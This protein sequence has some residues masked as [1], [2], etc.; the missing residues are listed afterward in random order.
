MCFEIIYIQELLQVSLDPRSI[1]EYPWMTLTMFVDGGGYDFLVVWSFQK[2]SKY[3][4]P[5]SCTSLIPL[6]CQVEY[7]L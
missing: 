1:Q 6:A 3:I 7:N 4:I 2:N 5:K